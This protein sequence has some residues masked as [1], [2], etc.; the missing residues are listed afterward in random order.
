MAARS[1]RKDAMVTITLYPYVL[2]EQADQA[3]DTF[4]RVVGID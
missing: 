2:T 4:A 1:G 3:V